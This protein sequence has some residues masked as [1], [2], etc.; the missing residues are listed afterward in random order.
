MLFWQLEVG[1]LNP[2]LGPNQPCDVLSCIQFRTQSKPRVNMECDQID[3]RQKK[4]LRKY[5]VAGGPVF[6]HFTLF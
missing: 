3:K 2:K 6:D 1:R 5:C 4:V